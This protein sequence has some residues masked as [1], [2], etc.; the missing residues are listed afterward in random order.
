M[1][2]HVV[3][4]SDDTTI[5]FFFFSF[6]TVSWQ[7]PFSIMHKTIM[8][9]LLHGR[10]DDI[11]HVQW[12]YVYGHNQINSNQIKSIPYRYSDYHPYSTQQFPHNGITIKLSHSR[13]HNKRLNGIMNNNCSNRH[14]LCCVEIVLSGVICFS[15]NFHCIIIMIDSMR[16]DEWKGRTTK[17]TNKYGKFWITTFRLFTAEIWVEL[18]WAK[19]K[20]IF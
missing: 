8:N 6:G 3:T 19:T 10:M 5:L 11:N 15:E 14:I 1:N 4:A 20:L 2:R 9:T 7:F 16:D 18:K 13:S 12:Y 17:W